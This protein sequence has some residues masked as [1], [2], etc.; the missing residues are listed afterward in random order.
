MMKSTKLRHVKAIPA[1]HN[2]LEPNLSDNEPASGAITSM[3][4]G[5]IVSSSPDVEAE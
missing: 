5:G 1:V 3:I 4:I 2:N